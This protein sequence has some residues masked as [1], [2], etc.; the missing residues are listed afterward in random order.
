MLEQSSDLEETSLSAQADLESILEPDEG[1]NEEDY[2]RKKLGLFF[3]VAVVWLVGL[4]LASVLADL[5]PLKD[6]TKKFAGTTR[7]GPSA[8]HWFGNDNIG[9]AEL[10]TFVASLELPDDVKARLSEMTPG[11]YIGLA[12]ELTAL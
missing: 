3:W 1:G 11:S 2:Q 6:P 8:A 12:K 10:Q 7:A 5:L 9:Q 4:I